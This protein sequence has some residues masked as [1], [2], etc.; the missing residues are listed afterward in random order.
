MK[1]A[2]CQPQPKTSKSSR[3]DVQALSQLSLEELKNVTGGRTGC[4]GTGIA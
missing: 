4:G 3:I 2:N 1:K